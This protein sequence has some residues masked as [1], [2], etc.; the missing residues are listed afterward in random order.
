MGYHVDAMRTLTVKMRDAKPRPRGTTAAY[1]R[2][3]VRRRQLIDGFATIVATKMVKGRPVRA[4]ELR[5]IKQRL[6]ILK[7]L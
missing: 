7:H 4:Q 2:M 5:V 3:G 6:T 1:L